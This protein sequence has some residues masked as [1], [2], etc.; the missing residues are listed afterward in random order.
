MSGMQQVSI[1]RTV[2]YR[3]SE[4][5]AKA[6]NRRRTNGREIAERM[7]ADP[8]RWPAGAQAHIGNSASEGDTVPLV[9]VRVWPHEFGQDVPGVNGQAFLDGND[10]LWVTSAKEGTGPGT[11]AWPPRA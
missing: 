9:V 4:D 2:H 5:D 1:G 7:K 3:L 8:P 10:A 11:W 6:I